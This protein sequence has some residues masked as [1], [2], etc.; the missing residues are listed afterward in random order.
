MDQPRDFTELDFVRALDR[1]PAVREERLERLAF[2]ALGLAAA[3][4]ADGAAIVVG[5]FQAAVAFV[6]G[7][8][9][10]VALRGGVEA[11]VD[12][13]WLSDSAEEIKARGRHAVIADRCD[14]SAV[15]DI[16]RAFADELATQLPELSEDEDNRL[17]A[18]LFRLFEAGLALG[19]HG[20]A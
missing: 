13:I 19:L 20:D 16:E 12:R 3:E 11:D 10:A 4:L 17:R 9:L 18:S 1:L 2:A 7:V 6:S 14:L 5:V 15:A 8:L